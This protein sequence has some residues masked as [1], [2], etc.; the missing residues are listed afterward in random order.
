MPGGLFFLYNVATASKPL[1][2]QQAP[3]E[4]QQDS[5]IPANAGTHFFL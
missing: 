3:L 4:K 5:V 1:E 2:K